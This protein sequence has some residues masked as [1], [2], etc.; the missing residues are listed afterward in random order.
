MKG[1]GAKARSHSSLD[2]RKVLLMNHS[3][4]A[5]FKRAPWHCHG[6]PY[7]V[8]RGRYAPRHRVEDR[9]QVVAPVVKGCPTAQ[10]FLEQI[11]R[12]LRI[13]FYQS[14]TVRN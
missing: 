9:L 4:V 6:Q 11:I 12:E 8:A 5:S 2:Y 10:E 3:P 1:I 13:R 14:H 7:A